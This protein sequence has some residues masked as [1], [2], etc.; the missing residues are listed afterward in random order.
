[1]GDRYQ[2]EDKIGEGSFG[3]IF[4]GFIIQTKVKIAIKI[5]Y[6]KK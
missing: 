1:L 3:I 6:K 4:S 2:I 5:E